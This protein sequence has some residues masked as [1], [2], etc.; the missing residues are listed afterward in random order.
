MLHNE[1]TENM[2]YQTAREF[3]NNVSKKGSI[4]GLESIKRLMYKL[5]N[6]QDE[7]KVVHI[8]GTNGKGS[9][10][11]YMLS[12]LKVAGYKTGR[13][14]SPAVFDCL[15]V[16]SINGE[17]ISRDDYAK[18]MTIIKE[19]CDEIVNEGFEMPT[20]FEVETAFAYKYFYDKKC[21][22]VLIETGMGGDYDATNVVNNTILSILSSI[23]M[24]HMQFL[25]NTIE[26]I[27]YHKSGIIKNGSRVI[28]AIQDERAMNVIR[29]TAEEKNAE[30]YVMKEPYNIRY[31]ENRTLFDYDEMKDLETPLRGTFQVINA[32]LAI[33]ALRILGKTSFNITDNNI[34][35]GIKNTIWHGRFEKLSDA[36][37]IYLDGGHNPG[38]AEYIRKSIEIYF[39]NRKIVYIIGVLADKDYDTVLRKTADLASSIITVTP[40]KNSRA[41]S[42]DDL[43][44]TAL[45]YNSNV[46]YE[47][48][49]TDAVKT[50]VKTA[51]NDGGIMIFGSLSYLSEIEKTLR[52]DLL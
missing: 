2:D 14:N 27:A 48:N 21:D 50:A 45:K 4:L 44:K 42:G 22:V 30:I 32:G 19:K 39:T 20:Y 23:S 11:A 16:F 5:G 6:V 51:G 47:E 13:Y 8:A 25:G 15:E 1:R 40:P 36:P 41:L 17:N 38:A 52:G 33:S 18:Y 37:L 10:L 7:L 3:I 46:L 31:E 9:T 28:T 35:T 34:R 29:K 43:R 12:V 24:D 49:I 26:E